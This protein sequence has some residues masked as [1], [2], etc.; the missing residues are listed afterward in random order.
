[1]AEAHTER[2]TSSGSRAK[3]AIVPDRTHP[4]DLAAQDLTDWLENEPSYY[5]DALRAGYRAPFSAKV[6]EQQKLDYYR[7]QI[8]MQNPDGTPDYSRPNTSGRDMLLKR[9]GI[10]GYTQIMGAVM[11][12]QGLQL[13]SPDDSEDQYHEENMRAAHQQAE[14]AP[15]G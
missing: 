3:E 10:E 13:A 7:R 8:F 15:G 11:P 6:S 4:W 9:V 14:M 2:K 12:S 1:V 5:V